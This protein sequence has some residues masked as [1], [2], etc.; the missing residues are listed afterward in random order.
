[1]KRWSLALLVCACLTRPA[2]AA[3]PIGYTAPDGVNAVAVTASAP[4]PVATPTPSAVVAGQYKVTASAAAIGSSTALVNGIV[5]KARGANA[6]AVWVG[7][8]GVNT[9]DDGTGA[10]YKLLP[11]EAA[12]FAVSNV[13]AIYAIGT[14]NDVLYF[15]GN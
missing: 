10:G 15:E 7:G 11:G 1:M 5:V 4:L 9:T 13:A 8:A 3:Q 14:A 2:L 6:G 12:S